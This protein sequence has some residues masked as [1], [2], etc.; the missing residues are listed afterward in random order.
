MTVSSFIS[1]LVLVLVIKAAVKKKNL[2][3]LTSSLLFSQLLFSWWKADLVVT[4]CSVPCAQWCIT[5]VYLRINADS[6]CNLYLPL[7]FV[8]RSQNKPRQY[9]PVWSWW[10]GRNLL[11]W[12][13]RGRMNQSLTVAFSCHWSTWT[14]AACFGSSNQSKSI[15]LVTT[16][17]ISI[18]VCNNVFH[19][20]YMIMLTC[21]F[22][23]SHWFLN[24]LRR[25]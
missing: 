4:L 25:Y 19:E 12:W 14:A 17:V 20:M 18:M 13:M 10:L 24:A 1:S 16:W 11:P 7:L 3:T 22:V 8:Q 2:I 21:S 9:S 23:T 5:F 15:I 6:E